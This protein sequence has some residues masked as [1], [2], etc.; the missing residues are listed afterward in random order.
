M[1]VAIVSY[2]RGPFLTRPRRVFEAAYQCA[3][4]PI[5]SEIWLN[6]LQQ[7]GQYICSESVELSELY[8]K[9]AR[10]VTPVEQTTPDM[11]NAVN[12]VPAPRRNLPRKAVFAWMSVGLFLGRYIDLG[13]V[14]GG[15]GAVC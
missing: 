4:T 9:S 3:Q 1:S 13:L 14:I 11:G 5:K 15:Q 8:E 2:Y 7:R 10:I 12:G 6:A